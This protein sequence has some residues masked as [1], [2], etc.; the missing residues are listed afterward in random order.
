MIYSLLHYSLHSFTL[1]QSE[2]PFK[3]AFSDRWRHN[4]AFSLG[5]QKVL[6]AFRG[7]LSFSTVFGQFGCADFKKV[8]HIICT[9]GNCAARAV[10][11]CARLRKAISA[12]E[13]RRPLNMGFKMSAMV[14]LVG[15]ET[16][17]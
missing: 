14:K 13:G 8:G 7:A 3:L 10:K 11:Q 17:N 12:H 16:I 4:N 1:I 15:T 9:R 5:A 2:F 6:Y